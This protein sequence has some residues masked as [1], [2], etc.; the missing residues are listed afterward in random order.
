[1]ALKATCPKDASHKRFVTVAHVSE[2]WIVDEHGNFIELQPGGYGETVAP[3]MKGNTWQCA[4]CG[5]EANV[6]VVS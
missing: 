4:D 3:P 2:E 5:A 6:E 1:M